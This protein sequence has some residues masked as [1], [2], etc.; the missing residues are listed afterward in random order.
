MTHFPPPIVHEKRKRVLKYIGMALS[1]LMVLT[2]LTVFALIVRN[3]S[4]HDEQGCPF[5]P[6]GERP[7]DG[8]KVVEQKRTCVNG[9]SE[10]RYLVERPSQKSFELARKRLASDRFEGGRYRWE[11]KTDDKKRVVL[12]VFVDGKPSS[13]FREEDAVPR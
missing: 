1:A 12:N 11:L 7:F 2:V 3:E 4:A 8:G 6:A 13:E 9:I 10:H 5:K